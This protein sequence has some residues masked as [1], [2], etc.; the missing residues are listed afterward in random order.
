MKVDPTCHI[1]KEAIYL[2]FN[3]NVKYVGWVNCT[4]PMK[5]LQ[6]P[7][8]V[9]LLWTNEDLGTCKGKDFKLDYIEEEFPK[10]RLKVF[11][12]VGEAS[13]PVG[14]NLCLGQFIEIDISNHLNFVTIHKSPARVSLCNLHGAE[15]KQLQ[16][17]AKCAQMNSS[18]YE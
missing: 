9:F 1:R 7:T 11:V 15:Y 6:E 18:R 8:D 13:N 14:S 5:W 17:V 4:L 3:Q 12:W 2:Q 10:E 16:R